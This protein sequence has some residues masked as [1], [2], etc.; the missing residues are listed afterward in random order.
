MLPWKELLIT[1]PFCKEEKPIIQ[2]MSTHNFG[3]SQWS[4][5][6]ADFMYQVPPVQKCDHCWKYYFWYDQKSREWN[7]ISMNTWDLTYPEIK[8]AIEQ[9]YSE[10]LDDEHIYQLWMTFL[11]TYNDWFFRREHDEE[12]KVTETEDDRKYFNNIIEKLYK[13]TP[14]ENVMFKGELLREMWKFDECIEFLNN[15]DLWVIEFVKKQILKH[16]ENHNRNVFVIERW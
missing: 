14:E 4:D 6:K 16:A 7:E 1:C 12:D 15:Q 11:W 9:L 5:T 3:G 8:E 2:L 10:D 13:A